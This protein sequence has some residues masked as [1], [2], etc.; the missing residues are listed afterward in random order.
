[1]ALSIWFLNQRASVFVFA[2]DAEETGIGLLEEL[3]Q[4]RLLPAVV[5]TRDRDQEG[6]IGGIVRFQMEAVP[7]GIELQLATL[8]KSPPA[9]D[10]WLHESKLDGYR[11]LCRIDGGKVRL[12]T[13]G[14]L[15]WTNR[16]AGADSQGD[17]CVKPTPKNVPQTAPS[18]TSN[19]TVPKTTSFWDA[20]VIE[21][22]VGC[23]ELDHS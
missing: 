17:A 21:H 4:I 22:R 16:L 9:G 2:I 18:Q 8:H 19:G 5:C 3:F 6:A 1:M 23:R 15:D 10:G 13:R 11:M 12:I 14:Q 7:A 20:V